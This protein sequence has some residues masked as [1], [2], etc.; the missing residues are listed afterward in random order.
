MVDTQ[1]TSRKIFLW[2]FAARR[3]WKG[4]MGETCDKCRVFPGNNDHLVYSCPRHASVDALEQ[5]VRDLEQMAAA[6][7]VADRELIDLTN[8]QV[9]VIQHLE[10][11]RDRLVEALN[12]R[13]GVIDVV[14]H[15]MQ[16]AD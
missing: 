2:T 8:R 14:D 1:M 13:I 16:Q 6:N 15:A 12:N 11:Q 10:A 9:K 4:E 5:Q 7:R 3:D